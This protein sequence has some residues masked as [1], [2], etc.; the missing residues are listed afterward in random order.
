MR[1]DLR[2]RRSLALVKQLGLVAAATFLLG[3]TL[4]PLYEI[5]CEKVFGIKLDDQAVDATVATS[6]G[7]D[8]TRTVRVQF[9]ATVNSSLPWHFKPKTFS[10]DVH[11]GELTEVYYEATNPTASAMVGNAVPSVAPST[12][13]IW[14]NKTECFCFTEQMLEAGQTRDLP[15][16]FVIDPKLPREVTTL[17]LGY[18][19]YLNNTATQRIAAQAAPGSVPAS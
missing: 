11:P 17:T 16:R 19:F 14:F 3:F 6:G 15:V 1:A 2:Q 7:V 10:I 12:A 13:S 18:V 8:R 4:V 5:A 9:D